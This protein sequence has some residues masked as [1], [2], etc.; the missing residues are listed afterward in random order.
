M[1]QSLHQIYSAGGAYM[2][3]AQ[4]NRVL[5]NTYL[6]LALSM[7]PTIAGIWMGVSMKFNLFQSLGMLG[8]VLV[9]FGVFY[10]LVFMIEKFKDSGMGVLLMLGLTF[11]LGLMMSALIGRT[12]QF[13]N[14]AALLTMAAG[15][16]AAILVVMAS[17]AT[18][19][20]RDF[21][22]IGRWAFI[23]MLVVIVLGLLNAFFFQQPVLVMALS[24]MMILL[25]SMMLLYTVNQIVNGGETNYI[26]AALSIYISLYNIFSN[27]LSLL[28]IFGGED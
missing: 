3:V 1:N 27:L 13:K 14:G 26:T 10:G 6:L 9:F 2:D 25:S 11:F 17:I 7:L 5:R 20:K 15:G 22:G 16:T 19:S 21:S 4:R 8:G 28:G 12:L 18:V 23:G 24:A